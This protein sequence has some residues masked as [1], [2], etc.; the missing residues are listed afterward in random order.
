MNATELADQYWAYRVAHHH[1]ENFAAGETKHLEKWPDLTS[2]GATR[3]YDTLMGYA[4]RVGDE[5]DVTGL[6]QILSETVASAA[7]MDAVTSVWWAELEAPSSQS[8]LVSELLPSFHLQPLTTADHGVRFLEKV[9]NFPNLVDQLIDRLVAGAGSG[10]VP[11]GLHVRQSIDQIDELLAGPVA[12][13]PLC[14]QSPPTDLN[15]EDAQTWR[16]AL[17]DAVDQHYRPALR[18]FRDTLETVTLPVG[19]D[20]DHPGLCH[21]DGGIDLYRQLVKAHTTLDFTAEEIHQIGLEQIARLE[22]EYLRLAGPLLGTSDVDEIYARLRD[23]PAFHYV[24]ADEVVADS[25]RCLEKAEAVAG[26]WFD[27]VPVARCIARGTVIGPMA[28]Y[29]PPSQDGGR[30]GQFFI[31]VA[32]PSAWARFQ[33]PAVAYHEGIPGHHLQLALGIENNRVHDVHRLLFMS[34]YGEGWGL[35]TEQLSDEM[36]LYED[37]WERVGMLMADS[38][39]AGRLVVDTGMHALGWT[40]QQAIDYLVNHSPMAMHEIREEIDRYIAS[41]GQALSYMIGRLEIESIRSD[42]ESALGDR[43]DIKEFHSVVLGNGT[44]PLATL[45]RMVEAWASAA[46]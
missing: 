40:R 21:L 36:G 19:R 11:V 44:V 46:A 27:P 14:G 22:Q 35:Y 39:R 9:A 18:R 34:A 16:A 30:D 20:E 41:P 45:R 2:G 32:D 24:D 37:D 43:F 23:D 28:F 17:E 7:F 33:V 29:L 6:D 5:T 12:D 38:M 31:N 10:I 3:F 1:W 4:G 13:D 15:D 42:A 8:G 25:L 26:D